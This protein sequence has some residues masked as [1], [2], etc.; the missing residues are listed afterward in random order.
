MRRLIDDLLGLSRIELTEHQPPVGR[1]RLA[2]IARAE[3][4]ALEPLLRGRRIALSLE[5]D[6]AAEAAPADPEQVAQVVRNLLENAV[7]HGREEIGRAAGRER[8]E[9]SAGA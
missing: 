4:E 3:A 6:E 1:A 9:L 7:R 8:V 5:L 2:E